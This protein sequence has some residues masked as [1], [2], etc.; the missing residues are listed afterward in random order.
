MAQ[1]QT[2]SGF[3]NPFAAFFSRPGRQR[4]PGLFLWRKGQIE[5]LG[6]AFGGNQT[7]EALG[8]D[9]HPVR[10]DRTDLAS[11]QRRTASRSPT[12]QH[13]QN[14]RI[15]R[16]TRTPNPSGISLRRNGYN[17]QSLSTQVATRLRW[18]PIQAFRQY[19]RTASSGEGIFG[20]SPC[21]MST[22]REKGRHRAVRRLAFHRPGQSPWQP[23]FVFSGRL[24]GEASPP[25]S[26]PVRG[27]A[28]TRVRCR[29]K[30]RYRATRRP[31]PPAQA[32][33]VPR[34]VHRIIT[35]SRTYVIV[36]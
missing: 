30:N 19:L 25:I 17:G 31:L 12:V 26:A 2:V 9:P 35:L 8:G 5:L 18:P 15:T 22:S 1:R 20:V 27:T 11:V 28:A 29:G 34:T 24:A 13:R 36:I 7:L 33:A 32:R 23:A 6:A 14:R 4:P 3:L 16:T 10:P 21:R